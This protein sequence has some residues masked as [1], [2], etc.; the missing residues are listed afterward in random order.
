[1]PDNLESLCDLVELR[2][3]K[4]GIPLAQAWKLVFAAIRDG[5]L[6]FAYP[7]GK[8]SPDYA[9][10]VIRKT[11]CVNA[12]FAIEHPEASP[13][14]PFLPWGRLWVRRMLV[15]TAAFEALLKG[16]QS[17]PMPTV[18]T[19]KY[20]HPSD[21]ALVREGLEAIST[22]R[23]SNPLQAAKLVHLRAEGTSD[24]Q[25]LDRLRKLISKQIAKDRQS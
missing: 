24:Q 11:Q 9:E 7:D 21:E 19:S 4:D 22:G 16:H 10:K 23:A 12:L 17:A 6:D 20:R 8:P 5:K 13:C 18:T 2:A 3:V 15:S 14:D 25:K 1:L